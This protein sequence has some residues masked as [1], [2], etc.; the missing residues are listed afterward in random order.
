MWWLRGGP[1]CC[2]RFGTRPRRAGPAYSLRSPRL[3]LTATLPK[4]AAVEPRKIRFEKPAASRCGSRRH[5][6]TSSDFPNPSL[7]NRLRGETGTTFLI[8]VKG[9]AP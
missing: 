5:A 2:F 9:C 7:R 4:E 3:G 6:E 1:P 8:D